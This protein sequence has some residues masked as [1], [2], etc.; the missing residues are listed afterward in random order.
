VNEPQVQV[1]T[2][3]QR[4]IVGELEE[5]PQLVPRAVVELDPDAVRVGWCG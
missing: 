3:G 4:R 2:D 1:S 5:R